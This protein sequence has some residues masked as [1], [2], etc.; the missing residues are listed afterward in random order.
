[1][2]QWAVA[3]FVSRV[4]QLVDRHPVEIA[5]Q[6]AYERLEA[7]FPITEPSAE[8]VAALYRRLMESAPA[9]SDFELGPDRR[10]VYGVAAGSLAS[11]AVV[12]L[13]VL[14]YRAAHRAVA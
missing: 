7:M 12:A 6:L 4:A 10:V 13:V 9:E 2:S 14:R 5:E 11:A 3:E 8:F 1:M